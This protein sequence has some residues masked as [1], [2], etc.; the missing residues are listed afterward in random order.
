MLSQKNLQA[1][2]AQFSDDAMVQPTLEALTKPFPA[3][4]TPYE[5]P[6]VEALLGVLFGNRSQSAL[7]S[8]EREM[9]ITTVLAVNHRGQG[10][11]LGIHLYWSLMVGWSPEQIS[12]QLLVIS[13]YNGI[14][15][16]SAS[17]KTFGT[18]L[19]QLDKWTSDNISQPE[20]LKASAIV[21][22]ILTGFAGNAPQPPGSTS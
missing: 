1:L 14:D 5:K 3:A 20:N 12:E 9:T 11:F 2:R 15:T 13:I 21:G 6:Y 7:T 10:P 18:L 17:F 16:L 4:A 22:Q 8:R 19:T